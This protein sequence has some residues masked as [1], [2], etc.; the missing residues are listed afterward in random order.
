MCGVV[1]FDYPAWAARYPELSTSVAQPLAQLYFNEAGLYLNNTA[2]SVVRDLSAR[3][4]LLNM[5][6]AHIAK[7]NATINGQPP[8]PLVGRISAAG[9]GS[10]SVG[11]DYQ[12]PGTAAWFAQT[13]YGAAYWQATLPY[14]SARY[15][16]GS[17]SFVP[18]HGGFYR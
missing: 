9:E 8:S 17:R 11:T 5:L 18:G 13:P 3:A 12:V 14:R 7:M 4:M 10:V 16:P 6:T 15:V 2:S 1:S